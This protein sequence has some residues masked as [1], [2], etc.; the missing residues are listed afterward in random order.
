MH[1]KKSLDI[2]LIVVF[3]MTTMLLVGTIVV[4]SNKAKTGIKNHVES[5]LGVE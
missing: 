1:T 4:D 2:Y 3:L 5:K